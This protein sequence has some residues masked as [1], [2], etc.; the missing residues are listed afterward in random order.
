MCIIDLALAVIILLI[1]LIP[2]TGAAVG[3][4]YIAA[5]LIAIPSVISGVD[6]QHF[7]SKSGICPGLVNS[8]GTLTSQ[9]FFSWAIAE[10][11]FFV[12]AIGIYGGILKILIGLLFAKRRDKGN[13][14]SGGFHWIMYGAI[15]MIAL[16]LVFLY[17]R[18]AG[19]C[20]GK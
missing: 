4:W 2:L 3:L 11:L 14:I 20:I 9:A 5:P 6:L 13:E 12:M 16:G 1:F 19:W 18:Q 15:A 17:F 7:F 8:S 10:G